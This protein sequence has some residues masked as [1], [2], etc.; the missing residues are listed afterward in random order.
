MLS[1]ADKDRKQR[2]ITKLR[3][4][5]L[6]EAFSDPA[7]QADMRAETASDDPDKLVTPDLIALAEFAQTQR[8][9]QPTLGLGADTDDVILVPGFLGSELTDV[10]GKDGLIWIDPKLVFGTGELM[11]LRLDPFDPAGVETDAA[12]GVIIRSPG[13]IPVIYTGLQYYLEWNNCN[14]DVYGFD[15]RKNLEE[16]SQALAKLIRDRAGQATRPLHLVAHSQGTV[17]A[18][19]ALQ[20][21]GSEAARQL[22]SNLVL[23]AP[24]SAGTF[25]A[26]FAIAGT[27]EMLDTMRK[28]G[29]T[30]PDGFAA[31]LQSMTG[32]YQLLPW[33]TEPIPGLAGETPPPE[34]DPALASPAAPV[35]PPALDWV[36]ANKDRLID[37]TFWQTGVD[38]DRL[39]MFGWGQKIDTQFF[40]DRTTIILGDKN[41]TTG[42]AKFAVN[43]LIPDKAYDTIGDGTV[44]ESLALLEGVTRVF[45]AAGAEHMMVPATWAVIAAVFA[46]LK[47][48]RPN[49]ETPTPALAGAAS[50]GRHRIPLLAAPA[51]PT[52][53]PV[54]PK[55]AP[56]T[57][58]APRQVS[59]EVTPHR[60]PT[61]QERRLRVF[62]FDP[63]LGAELDCLGI[64]QIIIKLPWDFTDGDFL[65]PGPIGEYL[66]VIDHDPASQCSYP[67]I[68]LNHPHLL[69]QDGWVASEG[70][71]RFHQ[72]MTFAVAMNTIRHFELAL[73]RSA[74]WSPHLPRDPNTGEVI[75][76]TTPEDEYVRRLRIYPHAMRQANAYYDPQ[77]KA[78]LFGYFPAQAANVGRNLPGGTVFTCLSHDVIAHETTHAL[79]DGLHR[80]LTEPSNPDVF[81]FHEAFADIVAMLQHFSYPEVV[82]HQLARSRGDLRR[83]N[84]LGVMA[85]QFGEAT[86]KRGALRQYIGKQDDKGQWVPVEPDPTALARTKEPH[87]RGAILVA[88]IFRAFTNIYE[89]RVEDLR[90]IAS[91]GSGI[92]PDGDLHPD[93]VARMADEAA[94]AARHVMTM[95][96]RALDYIAPVDVTFGG[97]LRALI[98]AD[99]DLVKDD[100]RRYRVSVMAAF[101]DWGIYPSDVRSLSIDGLVWKPPE[102]TAIRRIDEFLRAHPFDGWSLHGDRRLSFLQMRQLGFA[103]QDW[104]RANVKADCDWSLGLSLDPAK[105]P[106]S[107]RRDGKGRVVFEVHSLRPCRRIGPDG[108]QQTDVIVD[109]VQR[110]KAY[111]DEAKQKEVDET[112]LPNVDGA[113]DAVPHDFYFRG[114]CT[115]VIDPHTGEIRYCIRKSIQTAGDDRLARERAFRQGQFGDKVGGAYLARESENEA[116]PF[117]F[118]H[119]SGGSIPG[120]RPV[121]PWPGAPPREKPMP[122]EPKPAQ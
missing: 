87:D 103:F 30:P 75:R 118:L 47:G 40:N 98:T 83:E 113:Y 53:I 6:E 24:A 109:L 72:Q 81:A 18:R 82:R 96:I 46:V 45:K 58:A 31:V 71:P 65:Q 70:D 27:H 90:R 34:S 1:Q 44:P 2:I 97:Y 91:G 14:V 36:K 67:P 48:R 110:R 95:C 62:A 3:G 19:R 29:I 114:G 51:L 121:D 20:I 64:E 25:A 28:W 59:K 108:Q 22:V 10:A 86:G 37:P 43:K 112:P 119:A 76:G 88:A 84:L 115:L 13:A 92:L 80:Y 38:A 21:V 85:V 60:V 56:I 116:N 66:E 120:Y 23:L 106:H 16:S 55:V 111:F 11:D 63:L 77:R 39:K 100:D 42:G 15:W 69:A 7:L 89:N 105:A 107:I 4:R 41:P 50:T 68:D 101:R 54:T 57:P 102:H 26:A 104:L 52:S 94:K 17:V 12:V 74:L 122:S 5:R 49:L 99:Y 93:L 117:K 8:H 61:P 9:A 35:T 32:L 78:L 79:L 73:G 33:R